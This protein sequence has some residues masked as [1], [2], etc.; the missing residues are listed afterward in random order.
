MK[1]SRIKGLL[2][3]CVT[4]LPL[5]SCMV[6]EDKSINGNQENQSIGINQNGVSK[7]KKKKIFLLK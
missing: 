5:T 3:V 1:R 7:E 2:I 6:K 4:L